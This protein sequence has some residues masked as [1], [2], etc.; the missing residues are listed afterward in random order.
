M[1]PQLVS[2]ATADAMHEIA[3]DGIDG[4]G[5][6]TGLGSSWLSNEAGILK[7]CCISYF[8]DLICRRITHNA[9][10]THMNRESKITN[11]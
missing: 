10:L 7:Y 2:A 6:I 3:H 5:A 1:A 4:A 9:E 8:V 11:V